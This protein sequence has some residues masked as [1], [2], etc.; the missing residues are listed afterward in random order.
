MAKGKKPTSALSKGAKGR[1]NHG[2]KTHIHHDIYPK[3]LRVAIAK[4]GVLTKYDNYDSWK[5][6][7]SARGGRNLAYNEFA[8]F[9]VLT[10]EQKDEYFRN[11]KKR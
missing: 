5:L 9:V 1:K 10:R 8:N 6:A 2:P 4:C 7:V 3:A 11:I